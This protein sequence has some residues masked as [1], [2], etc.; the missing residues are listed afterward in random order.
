MNKKKKVAVLFGGRSTEHE[1]SRV[2]ACSVLSNIDRDK[3]IVEMIGITRD[4]KWLKYDG[5]ILKI[6]SGEWE[7]EAFQNSIP[8]LNSGYDH[9]GDVKDVNDLFDVVFPVLHGRNGE[10]GSVQGFLE[11]ADI[12]YVGSGVLGSG[13]AMDKGYAKIVFEKEG[14]PQGKYEVINNWEFRKDTEA[15]FERVI[16]NISLPCFVK[17]CNSGSSVGVS[18]ALSR[19]DLLNAV[20]EAFLYDNRILVEE[21]INGREIECSV[22][23]N[24]EP[25]ASCPGEIVPDRD[26]YDYESKYGTNSTAE[27][28]IPANITEKCANMIREYSIKAFKA[29]NCFGLARVDFFL[30]RKTDMVYINE[31][32]TM[33]GFTPISMYPKLW[34]ASGLSYS[35]LI[36]RLL[37]LAF[38]RHQEKNALERNYR[39]LNG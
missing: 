13:I 36:D 9:K 35:D 32:N 22:L 23:G 14:L 2:S 16:K 21:Y 15:F 18:K 7:K 24:Y 31:I 6:P 34:E 27:V 4:G 39:K 29:L 19:D 1:V 38:E 11:L 17:P 12:P 30:D 28:C 26:F 8:L 25:E 37:E 10:D 33:P 20:N 5:D 3:Y